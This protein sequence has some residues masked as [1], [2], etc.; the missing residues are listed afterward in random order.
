M[1]EKCNDSK[2]IDSAE[3]DEDQIF[4][5]DVTGD[6]TP[7]G[8]LQAVTS[9]GGVA[10]K[11]CPSELRENFFKCSDCGGY[12]HDD[13]QR[14]IENRDDVCD[15]CY[16]ESYFHCDDCGC[17]H[18]QNDYN[19]TCDGGVCDNCI[20]NYERC[21]E[22]GERSA[23]NLSE[24]EECPNCGHCSY[25]DSEEDYGIIYHYDYRPDFVTFGTA[26]KKSPFLGF[27]IEIE[28]RNDR[29][30]LAQHC[31]D[32]FIDCYLKN[33]GSLNDGF[34]VVSMPKTLEEHRE[35]GYESAMKRAIELGGRSHNTE[36]C[37]IHVHIDKSA[38]SEAHKVRF[39]M[40][41]ALCKPQLEVLARRD[42]QRWC[43]YKEITRNFR[44][45]KENE[46][47]RYEAINWLNRPT[48]EVRIFKGTLKYSTFMASME[49]CHAVYNFTMDKHSFSTHLN[50]KKVFNRFYKFVLK[51]RHEYMVLINYI[52]TKEYFTDEILNSA[53]NPAKGI[54]KT[55]TPKESLYK[56]LAMDNFSELSCQTLADFSSVLQE[57][58]ESIQFSNLCTLLVNLNFSHSRILSVL[59]CFR[60][61]DILSERFNSDNR[62][63]SLKEYLDSI[64][65]DTLDSLTDTS[66]L[67]AHLGLSLL[68]GTS[69]VNSIT[70]I[71]VDILPVGIYDRYEALIDALTTLN[72]TLEA[73]RDILDCIV[74][75]NFYGTH[76]N[77]NVRATDLVSYLAQ[78][79][80]RRYAVS[81]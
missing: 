19:S 34:E 81:F 15:D 4:Y 31:N 69:A 43:E 1:C 55:D 28:S 6:E 33:D 25:S 56:S 52:D 78:L 73:I 20:D 24:G 12:H 76:F 50:D 74:A 35:S 79:A 39:G 14:Y 7:K 61:S 68:F 11:V 65:S 32:S 80:S 58:N 77:N 53:P 37:G 5:C 72:Y 13:N 8:D 54:Y 10:M 21:E 27:E 3:S 62:M 75:S 70:Q 57:T 66:R 18:H 41:F 17:N 67:R 45:Y 64:R 26:T 23:L 22:C 60:E 30:E 38:M 44:D 71:A 46:G 2:P 9:S 36:T 59:Q 63:Y 40:F 48:V 51:N 49:L 16:C 29:E 42:S 47:D